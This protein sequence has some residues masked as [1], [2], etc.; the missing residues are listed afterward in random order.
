MRIDGLWHLCDDGMVRPILRGEIQASDGSWVKA[1]FL[2]DTGADRTV[3]SAD[4][5]VALGLQPIASP[6]RLSGVGGMADSVVVET[7]I[8]LTHDEACKA[9]FKGQF[10]AFTDVE[11]LDMCVIGRDILNLFALVVDRQGDTVSLV[12]QGHYCTIAKR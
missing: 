11:T 2:V 6:D 9:V 7:A 10:A 12:G 4:V 3:L 5:L 1:P 8:R